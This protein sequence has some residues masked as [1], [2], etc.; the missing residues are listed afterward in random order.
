MERGTLTYLGRPVGGD[1]TWEDC[2]RA[3]VLSALLPFTAAGDDLERFMQED[4]DGAGVVQIPFEM[5][6]YEQERTTNTNSS[7]APSS[8]LVVRASK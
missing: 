8:F 7:K 5:I 3:F 4:P 2:S 1:C 6:F